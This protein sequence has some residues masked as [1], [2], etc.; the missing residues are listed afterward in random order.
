MA[1][2][3][4]IGGALCKSSVIPF[5]V[6]R[7]KVWLMTAAGG[8]CSNAASIGEC[9]TWTKVNF[10]P[11]KILSGGKSPKKCIYNVPAKET[12]K[13]RAKF[14]WPPVSDVAAVTKARRE[15]R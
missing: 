4:N 12:A 11:G 7:R 5:L 3:P 15:T 8:P 2:L 1:A 14:G 6:R 13:H 10:G 9:K